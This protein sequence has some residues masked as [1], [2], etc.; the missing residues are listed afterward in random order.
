MKKRLVGFI[1]VII[2]A[3][4]LVSSAGAQEYYYGIPQQTVNVYY[5]ADGTMSLDYVWIFANQ[6][7][8]HVIDYVDVG[9]PY[10]TF[11]MSTVSADVGGT[12]VDVSQSDFQGTG[13]GRGCTDRQVSLL[14]FSLDE[15]E[16]ARPV[17][18]GLFQFKDV[19]AWQRIQ[20]VA[21]GGTCPRVGR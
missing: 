9:M 1:L 8:A 3:L 19:A 2:L 14:I 18:V 7:G 17:M 4:T 5:N 20:H 15:I 16:K 6:P 11:D 10:S 13:D 21:F 12:P